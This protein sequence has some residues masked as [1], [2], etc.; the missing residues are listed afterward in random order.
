[1]KIYRSNVIYASG[2]RVLTVKMNMKWINFYNK[3]RNC[4]Y[5]QKLDN[6]HF[7]NDK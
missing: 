6:L 2:N 4:F 7:K 1:M 3:W 5:E